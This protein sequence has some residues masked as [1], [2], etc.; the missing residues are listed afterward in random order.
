MAG[1]VRV[2]VAPGIL[3]HFREASGWT[4]AE[5]GEKLKI[6]VEEVGRL[7]SGGTRPTLA[8]L[9]KL[10]EAFKYP[11]AMFL[12]NEP[13]EQRMPEDYRFLPDGRTT[14]DKETL[15]AIR[16]CRHLQELGL[17]LLGNV[18]RPAGHAAGRA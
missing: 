18:G 16:E 10:S 15:W 3:R 12:L 2:D 8:Q 7:E 1:S 5:V 9:E 11:T 17:E 13:P 14:F 6:P 4:V